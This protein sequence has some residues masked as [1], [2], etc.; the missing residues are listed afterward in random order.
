MKESKRLNE[1]FQLSATAAA[2]GRESA[3]QSAS[4]H[5]HA[6]SRHSYYGGTV[7]FVARIFNAAAF[8][9]LKPTQGDSGRIFI[10]I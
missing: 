3:C 1:S 2:P 8:Q 10:E 9:L 4:S 6:A 7:I 5:C